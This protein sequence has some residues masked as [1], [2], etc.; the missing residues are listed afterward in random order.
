MKVPAASL[1]AL[2]LVSICSSAE[3]HHDTSPTFCCLRYLH[4]AVPRS[5][6]ISAYKTSSKCILPAV[7]LV[8]KKGKK[9]CTDPKARWVQV[10]LKMEH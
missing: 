8:T 3:I 6:I 7:I 2:L 10:H 4:H 1:A 5:H 9:L